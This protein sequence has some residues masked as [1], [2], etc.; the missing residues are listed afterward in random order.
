MA[1]FLLKQIFINLYNMKKLLIILTFF[2]SIFA[3]SQKVKL[4]DHVTGKPVDNVAV[5]NQNKNNACLS[6]SS[7]YIDL[8]NFNKNDTLTIQHPTYERMNLSYEKFKSNSTIELYKRMILMDEFVISASRTR[9]NKKEVSYEIDVIKPIELKEQ[10]SNSSAEILESTGNIMVQ[11]TQGGGGSPILRGFEANKVLLAVDGVR[12]NNAIYR[13][14]HLQNSITIDNFILD[15]VEVIYGPSSVIYGSDALGGVIHYYTKSPIFPDSAKFKSNGDA[16]IKYS[17]ADNGM[18]G[19]FNI[20]YARKKI[21]GISSVTHKII[22]DLT[23]GSNRLPA[24]KDWGKTPYYVETINGVDSTLTNPNQNIQIGTGYSQTDFLQKIIY[25]PTKYID[26]IANFQYSTSSNINRYDKL[27]QMKNGNLKYA[28]YYYGPQNRLLGALTTKINKETFLF[29]NINM[30][31]SFQKIDEDRISRKFRNEKKLYQEEDVNVYGFS[32]DTR[33]NINKGY[34]NYGIESYYNN[35]ESKAFYRNINNGEETIAQ[36]RYPDGGSQYSN[37]AA[38]SSIKYNLSKK[39]FLLGGFRYS[40]INA[41]SSFD[42]QDFIALPYNKIT[43]SNGAP[44]ASIST[45]YYPQD[46]LK[47]AVIASTGFRAPNV[48]DYGKIRAKHDLI[49]LPNDKLKPEY[50]YNL[51]TNI[52]KTIDGY[53]KVGGTFYYSFLTNAI[54]RGYSNLNGVDTVLYDGDYYH[55]I[56]NFNTDE[57]YIYGMNFY[58]SSDLNSEWSF[59]S[60]LNFTIGQNI[61]KNEP[62]GHI[63]P[64]F[65]KSAV[66]YYANKFTHELFFNYSGWK[67]IEDMSPF[68]EDNES[69]ATEDGFPGWYTINYKFNYT[70]NKHLFLQFAVNNILDKYY[71]NFAS[72]V[73]SSGRNFIVSLR[74]SF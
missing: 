14:G 67:K 74:A 66:K 9:E 30:N 72:A 70:I 52:D 56:S 42:N 49:T 10:T 50:L 34:I 68:G 39:L 17:S 38:Y 36:T 47:I 1:N 44:T 63:P 29:S 41:V 24:Y 33:K 15:R 21:G 7:G 57:A 55:I 51:E 18:M 26:F 71:K 32:I 8:S 53:I 23:V 2:Y 60:K 54:V 43:V 3:F 65:G 19:H 6:D 61:T 4:V 35:V 46:N 27:N 12:L 45:I 69:Q 40:Y 16:Y 31:I 73:G 20:T 59:Y 5:F 25:K 64:F 37:F 62:L 58:I 22:N 13:S 11:K 48:D 28:E